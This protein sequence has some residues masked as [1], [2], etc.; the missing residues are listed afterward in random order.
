LKNR[1]AAAGRSK[2]DDSHEF[3]MSDRGSGYPA[4]TLAELLLTPFNPLMHKVAKMVA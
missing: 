3:F 2:I 1:G 4:F